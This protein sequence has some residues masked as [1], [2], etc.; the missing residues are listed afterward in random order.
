MVVKKR[1]ESSHVLKAIG[2]SDTM[3]HNTI[4][5]SLGKYNTKEDV[6]YTVK[7]LSDIIKKLRNLS[8]LYD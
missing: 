1:V 3:A 4:R 7:Y 5:I 2:L 6:D 8:P